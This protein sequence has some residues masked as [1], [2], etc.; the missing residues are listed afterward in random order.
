MEAHRLVM[1]A[2]Q[3]AE[4]FA[5]SNPDRADAVKATADHLR[6]FWDP[7]MRGAIIAHASADVHGGGLTEVARLAVAQLAAESKAKAAGQ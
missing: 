3:I 2:N 6:R 4:F 1:M 7:R 5:T